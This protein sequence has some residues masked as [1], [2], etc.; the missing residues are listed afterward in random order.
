V[1]FISRVAE[2]RWFGNHNYGVTIKFVLLFNGPLEVV[3]VT[4]P[5]VA[6]AGTL[7]HREVADC[8]FTSAAIPLKVTVVEELKPCPRIS[9]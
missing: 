4:R 8:K 2:N 5:V 9:T 1:I 7:V 3:T 6:P